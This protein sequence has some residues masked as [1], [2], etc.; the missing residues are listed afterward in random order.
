M[1][2]RIEELQACIAVLTTL[3]QELGAA[4][5]GRSDQ[6][7]NQVREATPATPA[8]EV[9]PATPADEAKPATCGLPAG[10]GQ[11]ITAF[12]R[13]CIKPVADEA[14]GVQQAWAE[15]QE[16]AGAQP[17]K[18]PL[19][20]RTRFVVMASEVLG[21]PSLQ[22]AGPKGVAT[23]GLVWQGWKLQ[24]CRL[25]LHELCGDFII[26]FLKV[27]W[28]VENESSSISVLDAWR[29]FNSWATSI[30][31]AQLPRRTVWCAEMSK[32]L[33]APTTRRSQ[34]IWT[35]AEWKN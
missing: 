26:Q 1:A 9:T 31:V 18:E 6:S 19:P 35:H 23:G 2:S 25:T 29:E 13:A 24:I 4:T 8:D 22:G 32:Y 16:W 5:P 7:P 21:P 28:E 17:N 27:G 12:V 10:N 20:S 14:V 30:G 33:F 3:V 11:A 15:Y 34:Q